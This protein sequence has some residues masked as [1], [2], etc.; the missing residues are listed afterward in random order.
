MI[1]M[2]FRQLSRRRH[3]D[4]NGDAA[5]NDAMVQLGIAKNYL[6]QPGMLP[7]RM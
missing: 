4:K 2:I 3:P 1:D 7:F 5:A 6:K